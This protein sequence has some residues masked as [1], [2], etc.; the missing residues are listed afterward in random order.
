MYDGRGQR[1]RGAVHFV[2]L[3]RTEYTGILC[4]AQ[5]DVIEYVNGEHRCMEDCMTL[6]QVHVVHMSE[7]R[8]NIPT[9]DMEM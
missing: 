8:M 7:G 1:L 9:F 4:V 3:S 6:L 2:I 5:S